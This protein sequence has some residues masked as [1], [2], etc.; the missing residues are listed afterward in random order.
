MSRPCAGAERWTPDRALVSLLHA[1]KAVHKAV[2]PNSVELTEPVL[3]AGAQRI[4]G[5]EWVGHAVRSA[6]TTQTAVLAA[7]AA[8]RSSG[9]RR[10]TAEDARRVRTSPPGR[11]HRQAVIRPVR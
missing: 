10:A 5:G 9:A 1:L 6:I 11:R 2:D 7:S 4:A 8:A 3:N